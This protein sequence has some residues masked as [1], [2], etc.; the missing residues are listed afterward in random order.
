MKTAKAR[1]RYE[2][3]KSVCKTK[4]RRK[5][6]LARKQ[7]QEAANIFDDKHHDGAKQNGKLFQS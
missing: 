2:A 4:A 6:A 1:K 7:S 3:H 5:S